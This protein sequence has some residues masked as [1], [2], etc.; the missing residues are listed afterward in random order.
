MM[1]RLLKL[2]IISYAAALLRET[3]KQRH[4]VLSFSL[5]NNPSYVR[6]HTSY[7]IDSS[8]RI[9]SSSLYAKSTWSNN[10]RS[11][12]HKTPS[13]R[14]EL[15][16]QSRELL[17]SYERI[18][19]QQQQ[20]TSLEKQTKLFHQQIEILLEHDDL[21]QLIIPRDASSL[22]RLLGRNRIYD[23]MLQFCRRYCRD[24]INASLVSDELKQ[25][26]TMEE[27]N[28]A[29]LYCYTA[30]ISACSKP[31]PYL[32]LSSA[33][34]GMHRNK[35]FLLSLID[36]MEQGYSDDSFR[37]RPNSYTLSAV[38]LGIDDES[39]ALEVLQQFE[40]KYGETESAAENIVTVQVY[41]AAISACAR[42][43]FVKNE[44]KTN[45]VQGWQ[46]GLS[47]YN[48]MKRNGPAPNDQTVLAVLQ[49][50]AGYGQLR[51][52]MSIFDEMKETSTVELKSKLYKPLLK[53]CATAEKAQAA[54]NMIQQMRDDGIKITTEHMNLLLLA[55]AKCK[56]HT[57][58][59]EVLQE[60]IELQE[61]EQSEAPDIVTF[62]T[63]LSA[64]ANA[65]E[66]EAA[67]IL[68]DDMR[69]GIYLVP[70][71][72]TNSLVE[73]R[74]DVISY[75]TVISCADPVS[76]L[77][78]I[79]EMRLTRR[80]RVGV[81]SPNSISYTNAIARCRKA[82]TSSDLDDRRYAFDIAFTLFELAKES[83]LDATVPRVDLNVYLYS[84]LIWVAESVGNYKAAVQL[85]RSMECSPNTVCY[86]GVISA[87]SKRGLHREALYFYYEMQKLGL[88]R[89]R[90][91][92]SKLAF[93]INNARDSEVFASP[94]KKAALLEG[95]LSQMSDRDRAVS[96]GGPLFELL[97]R[98]HGNKAEPGSSHVTARSVFDQIKG[99]VD[100]ACL[101]VMVR[102]YSSVSMWEEAIMLL[103]C[104]DIVKEAT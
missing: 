14:Y 93:A 8:P 41:N 92:Y 38:L 51:V 1:K 54:E 73:V 96:I 52:A 77:E 68:L 98:C 30:A 104:S 55:L 25:N 34:S 95:V 2:A 56:M 85:L 70:D 49:A 12:R 46:V 19:K 103:H 18:G 64:C 40:E 84:S 74:P 99:P 82:S 75:N 53:T 61:I 4:A 33:Q 83:A 81:I 86:D 79:N 69:E 90:N 27:A 72:T 23:A 47:L 78:L 67:R 17:Q 26:Y 80:N 62:N 31:V 7:Y 13:N 101:S 100:N 36:E 87:L 42:S 21:T 102:V 71:D 57:R 28:E 88:H 89:T 97:I 65:D 16:T 91:I 45:R 24:M 43:S 29:I 59:L 6:T 15:T 35:T 50:L 44:E 39:E 5:H 9:H 60:M 20:C 66:Y 3:S 58:A 48:K 76:A 37:I 11:K 63:V 22:I 32:D 94:R 10:D